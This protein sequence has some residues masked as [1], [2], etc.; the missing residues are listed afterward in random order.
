MLRYYHDNGVVKDTLSL[1]LGCHEM[2]TSPTTFNLESLSHLD[3]SVETRRKL[4][5]DNTI[6]AHLLHSFN[7]KVTHYGIIVG[8]D[9]GNASYLLEV[10]SYRNGSFLDILFDVFDTQ[11]HAVLE[12]VQVNL[13]IIQILLASLN[14]LI[15]QDADRACAITDLLLCLNT[16]IFYKCSTNILAGIRQLDTLGDSCAIT[17][18]V[19]VS[20]GILNCHT[21]SFGSEGNLDGIYY[22]FDTLYDWTVSFNNLFAH[23]TTIISDNAITRYLL[24]SSG[25]V[26]SL[27]LPL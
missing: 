13:W 23:N 3:G 11:F 17:S 22:L 8:G 12:L 21:L 9:C 5:G 15:G 7:N 26:N 24:P 10:V 4:G 18:D 25:F 6:D 16:S 20:E 19:W 2:W 1:R 27:P 14:E